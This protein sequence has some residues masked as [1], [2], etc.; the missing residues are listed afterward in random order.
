MPSSSGAGFTSVLL[1]KLWWGNLGAVLVQQ[2][3]PWRSMSGCPVSLVSL[4]SLLA[5]H[6][7]H[8]LGKQ[9]WAFTPW[10]TVH[11]GRGN[12]ISIFSCLSAESLANTLEPLQWLAV[13]QAILFHRRRGSHRNSVMHLCPHS[14]YPVCSF[15][16]C[17]WIHIQRPLGTVPGR[18][19]KVLQ[20][21]RL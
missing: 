7:L 13:P 8:S 20:F 12:A 10:R 11:T 18:G 4:P 9:W 2:V 16:S 14:P 19:L 17:A 1:G 21:G 6:V 5:G 15:S 3:L